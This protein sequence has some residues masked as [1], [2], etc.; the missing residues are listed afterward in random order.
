MG[1]EMSH[2]WDYYDFVDHRGYHNNKKPRAGWGSEI[3]CF[4]WADGDACAWDL[5]FKVIARMAWA[6]KHL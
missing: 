4:C 3:G 1:I 5:R 2:I 6:S